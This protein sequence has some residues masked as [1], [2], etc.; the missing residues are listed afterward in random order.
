MHTPDLVTNLVAPASRKVGKRAR[1]A[2]GTYAMRA[3]RR[4]AS[5]ATIGAQIRAREEQRHERRTD[6]R[7]GRGGQTGGASRDLLAGADTQGTGRDVLQADP[8][9]TREGRQMGSIPGR[10]AGAPRDAVVPGMGVRAPDR[11]DHGAP[12]LPLHDPRLDAALGAGGTTW[13]PS[14]PG[15]RSRASCSTP[16]ASGYAS[17]DRS[18]KTSGLVWPVSIR[19]GPSTSWH[20]GATGFMA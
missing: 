12:F 1:P 9:D 20:A 10:R 6:A 4:P 5:A 14:D 13:R 2:E 3:M 11:G 17:G 7:P 8:A 19:Y 18:P 15:S 16:P